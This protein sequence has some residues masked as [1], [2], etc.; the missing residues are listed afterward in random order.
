MSLLKREA[1]I[2]G[3]AAPAP[4]SL[5]EA[6][7]GVTGGETKQHGSGSEGSRTAVGQ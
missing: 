3:T 7:V 5:A 6:H 4:A 1:E 2:V